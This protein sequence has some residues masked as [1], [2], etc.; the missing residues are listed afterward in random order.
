MRIGIGTYPPTGCRA[1]CCRR[2]WAAAPHEPVIYHP[3]LRLI[4]DAVAAGRPFVLAFFVSGY[5]FREYHGRQLLRMV[6]HNRRIQ[7]TAL[8]IHV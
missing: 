2:N 4:T 8:R 5:W 1:L 3:Q 7:P 6:R